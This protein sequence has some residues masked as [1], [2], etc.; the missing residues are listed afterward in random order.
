MQDDLPTIGDGLVGDEPADDVA[1]RPLRLVHLREM[2][3]LEVAEGDCDIRGWN[4]RTADGEKVGKVADLIVDVALMKVCYIEATIDREALNSAADRHVAIPITSARL[5]DQHDDVYLSAA[6][7][8][9]RSLPVY[10][11]EALARAYA[12]GAGKRRTDDEVPTGGRL[13][14]GSDEAHFFG[15]RRRG[16][17]GVS[18][19]A[20]SN[21][22]ESHKTESHKTESHDTGHPRGL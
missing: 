11:R 8:D 20:S 1:E 15:G 6:I 22:T 14:A 7:V 2:R 17:G 5:D 3:D 13:W 10:D 9:P 18:Y 4:L 12:G 21:K 16:R 19:L